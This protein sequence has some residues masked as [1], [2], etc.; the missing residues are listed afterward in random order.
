MKRRSLLTA[1]A[2]SL[3]AA[4]WP[5]RFAVAQPARS[6]LRYVPSSNLTLLDPIW[7]TAYVSLCHGY[8]VFDAL[9]GTDAQQQVKPQMAEGH[10]VSDDGRTWLIKLREGLTFHDGS[11]VLARDCV[12]S[13][14]RWSARN[15]TG[16]IIA[17][18]VDSWSA[19]DDRTIKATLKRPLPSL[20]YLMGMSVFPT[21]IMPERLARTDPSQ[22]VT[23]MM[24]SGPFRFKA[25]EYV[26]GSLTVYEKFD[27]YVPRSEPAE[28]T[29][30]GKIAKVDRI[31]WHVIPDSATAVS[32]LQRGEMDWLE[33]P[34]ADLLPK[35]K[36]DPNIVIGVTDPTGWAGAL[37]FNQL[38]APFN[39]EKVRQAAMMAVNQEDYLRVATGDDPSSGT[40]CPSFFPC[41]TAL[42][43]KLGAA[44][45]TGNIEQ[46]KAMLKASGYAGEKVVLLNPN[47]NPPIGDFAEIAANAF[48]Q[49]GLNVEMVTTDW[50]TV[51]QR[52]AK[53]DPV[54]QGGWSV[55][56]TTV[57]GPAI[58]NPAVNFMIRGQGERGYFGWYENAEI[59]KLTQDW[60]VAET[61]ADRLKLA[62]AIQTIAFRTVPAVPLGQF[63]QH[64]AYRK[65]VQG[66]LQGPAVLPWNISKV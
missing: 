42:G 7:S 59:E 12:A 2:T 40:V 16:Q 48:R 47:D 65:N 11:P 54:S 25:D 66:M 43:S 61:D 34:I 32:A 35:L 13:L 29:S 30:G 22:Q 44:A 33:R 17:S 31:E 60:L 19:P 27:G 15:A 1:G 58:M 23:E 10:S 14:I 6:V 21:F 55:F 56:V 38:Q 52:R 57:N 20:V 41:G 62:D 18:F 49:I 63:V 5:A 37:R 53:K 50:G 46:A 36:K 26:S 8:A 24:G 4:A 3:L 9:Y 45:M 64:T 51:T 28:G 39:N